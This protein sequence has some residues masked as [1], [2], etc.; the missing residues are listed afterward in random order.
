MQCVVAFM[1]VV[2]LALCSTG[3][4]TCPENDMIHCRVNDRCTRL[5]Y[6][7][8]GDNDCGDTSDEQPELCAA[9]N[10]PDCD[11]GSAKCYRYGSASCVTM[12]RFCT[13]TDPPCEGDVDPRICQMVRDEQ[14]DDINQVVVT[15]EVEVTGVEGE[16]EVEK[17]EAMGEEFDAQL[18][19]T[20]KSE[21]CPELYTSI[22]GKCV[23]VFFPG[24]VTWGAARSFCKSIGGDLLTLDG[25]YSFFATLVNQLHQY[26]VTADFW[27]GGFKLNDTKPW[28]W[29]SGTPIQIGA[30][31]WAIRSETACQPRIVKSLVHP[32]VTHYANGERCYMYSTAPADPPHG[33]CTA[34]T[35][36]LMHHVS[37]EDCLSNRSPLCIEKKD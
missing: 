33:H 35:Y 6:I 27:L 36:E 3:H 1:V 7:C 18:E 31:F 30:P 4:A 29:T 25:D 34:L 20:M 26:Q 17:A 12:S 19:G 28:T 10:Q 2:V 13:L 21:D 14:L 32:N 5:R 8:D 23:S 16:N 9:W 15:G 24:N 22:G 11:R 37:D